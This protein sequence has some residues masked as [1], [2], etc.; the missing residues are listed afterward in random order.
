MYVPGLIDVTFFLNHLSIHV[1]IFQKQF[2]SEYN[3]KKKFSL[4]SFLNIGY[5]FCMVGLNEF[6]TVLSVAART[7]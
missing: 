7:G 6:N 5:R 3:L 2:V 1:N 4:L